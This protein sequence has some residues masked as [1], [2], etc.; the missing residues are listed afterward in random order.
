MGGARGPGGVRARRYVQHVIVDQALYRDG[1]RQPGR[2]DLAEL[3]AAAAGPGAMAWIDIR[4]PDE[5]EFDE[6]ARLFNLHPL[7]V[8]D[9]IHAHQRPKLERYGETLFCVLRPARYVEATETVEFDELHVFIG[10]GFVI[11]VRQD[12]LPDVGAVRESLERRPGVLGEG[13]P[14]VLHALMDRVVDDYAPV[15][16]GIEGDLDEIEDQVFGTG[17]D[18][19]RR[20]YQLTREVIGFQRAIRPLGEMSDR[21]MGAEDP[22]SEEHRYLRD[23]HDHAIRLGER[24]EGFR[25]LLDKI[26]QVNLT[27]EAKALA[28]ASNEQTIETKKISA[29]AAIIFAPT[30]VG[31]IYGMNFDTMP[32]LAWEW[33]YPFAILL[34]AA[35]ALVLYVLFKR[36]RWI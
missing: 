29:W 2:P 26:L 9:A 23:V 35:I 19:S 36:R 33:G 28:E 5:R 17:D 31:T 4:R 30:L 8:E 11:S 3:A 27:L 13:P 12:D 6:V 20:I 24:V 21:L 1:R 16:D 34:M 15:A 25:E 22:S 7:A 32:E 14:A 10:P 18:A